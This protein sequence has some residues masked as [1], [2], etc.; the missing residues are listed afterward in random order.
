MKKTL[1]API[2]IM[3]FSHNIAASL[4]CCSVDHFIPPIV[5]LRYDYELALNII[6]KK[7][8]W[9][10]LVDHELAFESAHSKPPPC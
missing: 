9:L 4:C 5:I 7:Y 2:V 10:V 6:V 1:L 3:S 8:L